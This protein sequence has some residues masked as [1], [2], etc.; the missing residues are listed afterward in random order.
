M[1]SNRS[2]KAGDLG[3]PLHQLDSGTGPDAEPVAPLAGQTHPLDRADLLDEVQSRIATG[4][5]NSNRFLTFLTVRN[6]F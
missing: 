2:R 1:V 3:G 4:Q 6:R 5:P